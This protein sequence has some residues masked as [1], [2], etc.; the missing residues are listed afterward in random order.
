[1]AVNTSTAEQTSRPQQEFTL[2]R[3]I[4]I[5]IG[6]TGRHV[7]THLKRILLESNDNDRSR[8]PHVRFLSID[9]DA[10]VRAVESRSGD[11]VQLDHSELL[12]LRIPPSLNKDRFRTFMSDHV[13][14]LLAYANERGAMRC[15]PIG[16]AFLVTNWRLIKDRL[17]AIYR[18]LQ[19]SNMR[20]LIRLDQRF[21]GKNLDSRQTDIYV[22]GNLVS[23]T[24]SGMALGMGYLLRDLL[25]ELGRDGEDHIEGIFTTCG[26]F[27]LADDG[28]Q[29]SPYA[30]N[31]YA[32]LL[33]LNHY[34]SPSIYKNRL[35]AY[36]AGFDEVTVA[37][38]VRQRPPY[39]KVQLLNPSHSAAGNLETEKFEPQIAEVLALRTGSFVGMTASAKIVDELTNRDPYDR[40]GNRRFCWTWGARSFRSSGQDILDL[41]VALTA[42]EVLDALTGENVRSAMNR[43]NVAYE[44]LTS[45]GFGY[46][47]DEPGRKRNTSLL[48]S[49][50]TPSEPVE[51]GAQGVS[52]LD[53]IQEVIQKAFPTPPNDRDFIRGLPLQID[54]RKQE[55][56]VR[57]SGLVAA[58]VEQNRRML[59]VRARDAVTKQIE[60]LSDFSIDGRGSLDDSIG[61]IDL[62]LGTESDLSA[63]MLRRD[64]EQY[65]AGAQLAMMEA[66]KAKALAESSEQSV[67]TIAAMRGVFEYEALVGAWKNFVSGLFQ[68]KQG[69]ARQA[70]L[71]EARR[72]LDGDATDKDEALRFG[73]IKYLEQMRIRLR[74]ARQQLKAL[75]ISF[76]RKI[77]K[78]SSQLVRF[79]VTGDSSIREAR[80]LKDKVLE[81]ELLHLCAT[82]VVEKVIGRPHLAGS[83]YKEPEA[84]Q[85]DYA[86]I[87]R[88]IRAKVQA[89]G[90]DQL[91][92]SIEDNP[93]FGGRLIGYM[94][95]AEPAIRLDVNL[96]GEMKEIAYV[97]TPGGVP[98]FRQTLLA[99]DWLR[100]RIGNK[101]AE[102]LIEERPGDGDPRVDIITAKLTFSPA[103]VTGIDKW[104]E[105][106]ERTAAS[107]AGRR[108]IHTVPDS[109]GG[110]GLVFEPL[111]ATE[112]RFQVAYLIARSMEWLQPRGSGSVYIYNDQESQ[113]SEEEERR[114]I[115]VR[116][117]D[118]DFFTEF[119][120]Q[121]VAGSNDPNQKLPIFLHVLL[122]FQALMSRDDN[123][124][125]RNECFGRLVIGMAQVVKK[126]GVLKNDLL[127]PKPSDKAQ[128]PSFEHALLCLLLPL[129]VFDEFYKRV[130]A[131]T[132]EQVPELGKVHKLPGAP[133]S[134]TVQ[135][136]PPPVIE[137]PLRIVEMVPPS[138][139]LAA[140]RLCPN[141]HPVPEGNSF[142]GTC[143]AHMPENGA[144][145][146]NGHEV[147]AGN[148]F[149]GTCGSPVISQAVS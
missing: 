135:A 147:P 113:L 142:C 48:T 33:E 40:H 7:C 106:Y 85:Q 37:N 146:R 76:E 5:G 12:G 65:Q 145:C 132:K 41:A 116:L 78:L 83:R 124:E 58:V 136:P 95:S 86:G 131:L 3:S 89:M 43:K 103:A 70:V 44:I 88:V 82:E 126:V 143:G 84:M 54:R 1:M 141:Q 38:K 133:P 14:S 99:S 90:A 53:S 96:E 94:E 71:G 9:T 52:L 125:Q 98:V 108:E 120:R 23:G 36:N 93:T 10:R 134:S 73:L 74:G 144:V 81:G 21:Q 129:G 61:V 128:F 75:D 105:R 148:S 11:V 149:C 19:N 118:P 13:V 140:V 127:L 55:I 107:A 91:S 8:F 92:R 15:R 111:G 72:I 119:R 115:D 139:P 45:I 138:R 64:S 31:C 42:D 62:L 17:R 137:P 16:H 100:D 60:D 121:L 22:I 32:S 112:T 2:R 51:G 114:E 102:D 50:L 117:G 35:T 39:D 20:E 46:A 4:I 34:S 123:G 69:E 97:S 87:D 77:E 122:R 30:V 29:P 47:E 26:M 79:E 66:E 18:D 28:D 49:L 101:S 59:A 25:F 109:L 67:R 56:S 110:K 68:Q 104:A 6:G 24:G 63:G 80:T 130:K 27:A 57:I